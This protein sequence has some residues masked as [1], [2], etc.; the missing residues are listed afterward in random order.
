MTTEKIM[1]HVSK[2]PLEKEIQEKII[3]TLFESIMKMNQEKGVRDFI[4]DLL[5]PTEKIMLAKRL[6]AALLLHRGYT[7]QSIGRILKL[8]PTTINHIQ[9][10]LL[11]SG[12]GYRTAFK[13]LEKSERVSSLVDK[14]ER[15]IVSVVPP[16][17]GSRKSYRRWKGN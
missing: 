5:T 13:I 8:S 17:K 7:Y 10:D 15:F 1:P 3:S 2:R 9:S 4:N 6:G 16:V 12:E 14:I 11:K